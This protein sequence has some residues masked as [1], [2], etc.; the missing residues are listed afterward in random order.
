M[1]MRS[2][3]IILTLLPVLGFAMAEQPQEIH[4]PPLNQS[5]SKVLLVKEASLYNATFAENFNLPKETA[6]S[7]L[8]PDVLYLGIYKL[9]HPSPVPPLGIELVIK[10]HGEKPI[11]RPLPVYQASKENNWLNL[12]PYH[13]PLSKFSPLSRLRKVAEKNPR[14]TETR[15]FYAPEHAHIF[16][17]TTK[18]I[19]GPFDDTNSFWIMAT[20]SIME[21]IHLG[22]TNPEDYKIEIEFSSGRKKLFP[23]PKELIDTLYKI[24]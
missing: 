15:I 19:D 6:S 22:F 4:S 12:K 9:D 1:A 18:V 5:Y 17:F 20:S 21:S 8:D 2:T 23:I 13:Q 24:K 7:E 14:Y 3:A 10:M 11:Y 16:N